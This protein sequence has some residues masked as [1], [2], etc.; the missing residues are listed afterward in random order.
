MI[1]LNQF[2]D[3]QLLE[4]LVKRRNGDDAGRR[5][6]ITFCDTC[7]HFVPMAGLSEKQA[8]GYN[9]C[10]F[11]H[12]LNFRTPTGYSDEFGFFRRVCADRLVKEAS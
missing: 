2:T 9:P 7:D 11:G 1:D 5:D 6:D 10:S 3:D 12:D 8:Q 4:E